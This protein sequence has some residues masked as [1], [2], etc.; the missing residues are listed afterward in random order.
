MPTKSSR[1]FITQIPW[2]LNQESDSLVT[3][4]FNGTIANEEVPLERIDFCSMEEPM[5]VD[6][7]QVKNSEWMEPY[8]C[9]LQNGIVPKQ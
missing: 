8:V 4:A 7:I 6:T 5:V 2:T 1:K 9:Y 3:N